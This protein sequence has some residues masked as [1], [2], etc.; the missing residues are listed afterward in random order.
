MLVKGIRQ[1]TEGMICDEQGGVW[2]RKRDVWIKYLQRDGYAKTAK[3]N[4]FGGHSGTYKKHMEGL[5]SAL[6][7][8]GLGSTLLKGVQNY[9]V[10]TRACVIVGNSRSDRFPVKVRLSR[11]RAMSPWLFNIFMDGVL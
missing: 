4:I 1:G 2:K 6:K 9:Y 10:T 5:W 3:S 11:G 7:S 8:Y